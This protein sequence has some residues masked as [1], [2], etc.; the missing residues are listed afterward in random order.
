MPRQKNLSSCCTLK[1]GKDC[2]LRPCVSKCP[3][4]ATA[5]HAPYEVRALQILNERPQPTSALI[6]ATQHLG[7][8]YSNQPTTAPR[9]MQALWSFPLKDNPTESMCT[10]RCQDLALYIGYGWRLEYLHRC[11]LESLS[12][13]TEIGVG[14]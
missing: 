2:W 11:F 7:I 13:K 10:P 14:T 8:S 4:L 1:W 9:I 3:V 12:W 5:D 6:H